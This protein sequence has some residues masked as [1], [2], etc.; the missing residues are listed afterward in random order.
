M[1]FFSKHQKDED[2]TS[3]L[4][5]Q[6]MSSIVK[7]CPECGAG[8]FLVLDAHIGHKDFGNGMSSASAIS[9]M[10]AYTGG[11]TG[12][13]ARCGFLSHGHVFYKG[14][15]RDDS[16]VMGRVSLM[17]LDRWVETMQKIMARGDLDDVGKSNLLN[18]EFASLGQ[19]IRS[20]MADYCAKVDFLRFIKLCFEHKFKV[21]FPIG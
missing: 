16:L 8:G 7:S 13:C 4:L 19:E 2:K 5:R 3:E 14:K 12:A 20:S 1:G 21:E 9:D 15:D 17:I 18:Q 6:V 11:T 10:S